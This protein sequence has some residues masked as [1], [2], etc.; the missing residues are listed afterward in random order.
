MTKI[1]TTFDDQYVVSAG[2]DGNLFVYKF[3]S[4]LEPPTVPAIAPVS[5]KVSISYDGMSLVIIAL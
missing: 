1:V 3:N 2:A 5:D 4:Q